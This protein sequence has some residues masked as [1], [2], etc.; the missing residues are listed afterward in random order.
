VADPQRYVVVDTDRNLIV[1][2]PYLWDGDAAWQA[3]EP[4]ELMLERDAADQGHSWPQPS[5]GEEPPLAQ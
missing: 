2:G 5:G 3:P 1:G 4:G